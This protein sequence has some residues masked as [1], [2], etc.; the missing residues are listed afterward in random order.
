MHVAK[1][2]ERPCVRAQA[3]ER[4]VQ[5]LMQFVETMGIERGCRDLEPFDRLNENG[6]TPAGPEEVKGRVD[7]RLYR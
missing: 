1:N 6:P 7:G 4:G 5:P 3:I 2:E